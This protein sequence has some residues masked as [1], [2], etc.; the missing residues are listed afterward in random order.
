MHLLSRVE[1]AE[2]GLGELKYFQLALNNRRFRKGK[3]FS[4]LDRVHSQDALVLVADFL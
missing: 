2:M 4:Y 1:T 3:I